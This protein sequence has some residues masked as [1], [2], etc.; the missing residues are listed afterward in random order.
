MMKK[1]IKILIG[2]TSLIFLIGACND[3]FLD[4]KVLDS[5]APESLNDK[6][7]YDAAAIGL[8]NSLS[9]L[10]STDQDQTFLG[11]FQLGTDIVW[12]PAGR[13][14]GMARP[15]FDYSQLKSTDGASSKLWSSLYKIINNANILIKSAESNTA[16][17]MTPD[18]INTFNA[19]ARF[20]RAYCYNMLATLYGG[21]PLVKEP[22]SNAK[23]DFTRA[24]LDD[25]NKLIEDDLLFA[26][27]KLPE[28]DALVHAA[29]ANKAMAHQLLAE[30]YLRVNK[31][32][33]AET[34]CDA[35]INSGKFSIMTSRYGVKANQPGDLFSDMFLSGN[36]RR[37]QGNTEAIWV[38]EQENPSAVA[39]GSTGNPQQRRVWQG[40]YHELPGM[41]I[42]DTLGGRGLGRIRLDNWVVY[43][44]YKGTDMRNSK[45]S[46]HRKHYFNNPDAKYSAVYGKPVPYGQDVTFTLA[47]NSE[48]KIFASDT[49][50][51]YIPYTLKWGYF[52]PKDEFGFGTW[53]DFIIMRLGETYLL[54]AEAR[55][56]RNNSIGAAADINV[57][58]TRANAALVAAGDISLNFILD[59]RVRELLGEENR[60][61]TLVRTGTLVE[62]AT[63]LNGTAP[64]AGGAIE[65]TNG[66]QS[67]HTLLPIP[68]SEID[69]NKDAVLEQNPGYN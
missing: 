17:G 67:F 28:I 3:S 14:N 2:F 12:A 39:N 35:I 29:R 19:E 45:Y 65:T 18:E 25:V 37:K 1:Y 26:A 57:L 16:V 15:Y 33:L 54:R 10:Y 9:T 6:L 34:Q 41:K 23:T 40:S 20:F 61:M 64:L 59:E 21:V 36:Q 60:R 44:L 13:S 62:R 56:K 42:A 43:K 4:E 5:F 69:L 68:Q 24:S 46:I 66:L 58:R 50:Y 8:Y 11:V 51:K 49:I 63:R 22:V 48:L 47:D 52:D 53:K 32:D 30:F 38:M 7:G 31:P 27:D 55:F